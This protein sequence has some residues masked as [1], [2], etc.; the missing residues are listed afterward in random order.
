MDIY[1]QLV[2]LC[3]QCNK[4]S[5]DKYIDLGITKGMRKSDGSGILVGITSISD[6]YG[7]MDD[8]ECEGKITYRG[9]DLCSIIYERN[10]RYEEVVYLLLFGYLPSSEQL[11]Q[12]LMKIREVYTDAEEYLTYIIGKEVGSNVIN[13]MSRCILRL[14]DFDKNPE[15][16]SRKN[17][18]K[19]VIKIIAL[20]PIISIYAY[21]RQ[22]QSEENFQVTINKS[23]SVAENILYMLRE[24]KKFSQLEARILDMCLIIHAELGGGNNSAFTTHVVSSTGT[25]TYSVIAAAICSIKGPKHGGANIKAF[26]MLQD[27]EEKLDNW[28]DEYAIIDYLKKI[29]HKQE[30]DRSGLIYGIGHAVFTLSDP[31]TGML[32]EMAYKL[33]LE[34]G[35]E[36]E[37]YLYDKVEQI[38]PLVLQSEK[39]IQ[40]PICANVD[41]YSGFIYHM[42]GI[43]EQLFTPMFV[44]ARIAGW[45]AHRM[46]EMCNNPRIMHP[47]YCYISDKNR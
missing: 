25:D 7:H 46:E 17:M 2:D 29:I 14:Y 6:S 13:V 20:M 16:A 35:K 45:G 27:M 47:N 23:L 42:L 4:I 11:E 40:K 9:I 1:S 22:I 8:K 44:N 15:G 12:F 34:K 41:Y 19:Q 28:E 36:K 10:V 21:Q 5:S 38:A 43:P 18:L 30:F 26:Q 32:K 37:Y 33:A 39:G 3:E 24:N 31:R